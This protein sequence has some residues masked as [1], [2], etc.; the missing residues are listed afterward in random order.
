MGKWKCRLSKKRRQKTSRQRSA[1]MDDCIKICQTKNALRFNQPMGKMTTTEIGCF[2]MKC[3]PEIKSNCT[4]LIYHY[5]QFTYLIC[6]HNSNQL[7][8][9]GIG[10]KY[11]CSTFTVNLYLRSKDDEMFNCHINRE[12]SVDARCG[13]EVRYLWFMLHKNTFH[14][15]SFFCLS[16]WFIADDNVLIHLMHHRRH[17]LPMKQ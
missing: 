5:A 11:E 14:S 3:T 7:R 17:A 1:W 13:C 12:M 6:K 16:L 9:Q 15:L 10:K 2:Q 4:P 8:F